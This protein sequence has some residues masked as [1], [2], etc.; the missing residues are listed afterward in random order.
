MPIRII[1]ADDYPPYTESLRD[2]LAR[3]GDIDVIDTVT[4]GRRAVEAARA[5]SPDVVVMDVRMAELNGI[6]A[7]RR[8]RAE[9]PSVSVLALST[10]P[11]RTM[12]TQMLRA[13][14]TGYLL[15]DCAGE[16]LVDAIRA[17]AGGSTYLCAQVADTFAPTDLDQILRNPKSGRS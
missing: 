3:A 11:D 4:D 8:I 12:V 17:V 2:M 7:T 10:Y 6:E 16:E 1:L 15:K 14:A 13:G 9:L 5:K